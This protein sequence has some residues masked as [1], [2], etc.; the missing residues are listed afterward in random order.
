MKTILLF[1]LSTLSFSIFGQTFSLERNCENPANVNELISKGQSQIPDFYRTRNHGEKDSMNHDYSQKLNKRSIIKHKVRRSSE[2]IMPKTANTIKQALDSTVTMK[3][4]NGQFLLDW[5]VAYTYDSSERLTQTL[6]SVWNDSSNQWLASDKSNYTF[7]ADGNQIEHSYCIWNDNQWITS[8]KNENTYNSD[9]NTTQLIFYSFDEMMGQIV[10][11]RKHENLYNLDGNQ[12]G[13]ILYIWTNNQWVA[14]FKWEFSLDLNGVP[15][16]YLAYDWDGSQFVLSGKCD[17]SYDTDDNLIQEIGYDWNEN[18][19]QWDY[20]WKNEYSYDSFGNTTLDIYYYWSSYLLQWIELYEEELLY[21]SSGDLSQ[22]TYFDW[23]FPWGERND[24]AYDTY[25]NVSE[26]IYSQW[27]S[28]QWIPFYKYEYTHN[29][30]YSFDD[31]ILPNH[32]WNYLWYNHMLLE[33]LGYTI[34]GQGNWSQDNYTIYYYSET[35]DINIVEPGS[36]SI[37]P[38]PASDFI[39]FETEKLNTDYHIEIFDL[40]GREVLNTGIVKSQQINIGHLKSSSY[41]FRVYDKEKTF[42]GKFIKQ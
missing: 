36:I 40:S 31:L 9:G 28:I 14:S 32:Q 2:R 11:N 18:T 29:N 19:S 37:F 1:F 35:N 17:F 27:D 26:T 20:D 13:Y 39:Y 33:S 41:Y 5:K 16:Q 22:Y 23:T 3:W 6:R 21:N 42:T 10:P 25:G 4:A 24:Y 34:D 8:W 15:T 7:D 12:I 30:A 38:N